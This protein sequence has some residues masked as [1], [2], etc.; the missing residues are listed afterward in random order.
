MSSIL[1]LFRPDSDQSTKLRVDQLHQATANYIS[2]NGV[3]GNRELGDHESR[4][5]PI[6]T[7][8]A[9][10][11]KSTQTDYRDSETQTDPWIP[12]CTITADCGLADILFLN[13]GN[14]CS[15]TIMYTMR[16]NK[17]Y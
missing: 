15:V 11:N 7:R 4:S 6:L 14:C 16:T 5:V 13:T 12:P 2:I 1:S 10:R 8:P 17:V 9:T 3:G